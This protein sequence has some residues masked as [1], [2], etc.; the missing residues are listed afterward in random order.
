M[1]ITNAALG[2]TTALIIPDP[3]AAAGQFVLTDS[4][5]K[6]I[7]SCGGANRTITLSGNLTT[8]GAFNAT[9]AVPSSSTWTLPTGGGTLLTDPADI[10]AT[11]SETFTLN[12]GATKS[13]V[14]STNTTGGGV[15]IVTLENGDTTGSNRT[16]TLPDA[17]TTLVGTD[18][19]Q[20][21]STKTLTAP[22][23]NGATS[24]GASN[25]DLSGC[26]GTF[27]TTTGTVTI[28][29]GAVSVTG[30]VTFAS[31]VTIGHSGGAGSFDLSSASGTFDTSTGT[32]T[33]RG[34]VTISG[35][36]T[37]TTGTGAAVLKGSATFDTTKS[38][39]FGAA[40]GGTAIPITMYSLTAS[41]GAFILASADN[42]T[43][44]A[45][46]LT[47]GP[48]N[49]A[50]ATITT[51]ASTCTLSG[52]GLAETFSGIKTFSVAPVV[53]IDDATDNAVTDLLSIKHTTSGG[54]SAGM[55]AGISVLIEN[56]T[57]ATTEA[58]SVDFVMTND[59]TKATLDVDVV[60]NTML[61]GAVQP[62]LTVDA[63]DQSVTIGQNVTDT[64]GVNQVRIYPRTASMGS[65]LLTVVNNTGDTVTQ[66]TNAGF[67]QATV[68][69]IP[70]PGAATCNLAYGDSSGKIA[71]ANM[72]AAVQDL[73]PTMSITAGAEAAHAR[74]ITFQVKDA[75]SNNLSEY[76]I[77]RFFIN[78]TAS[79]TAP[80]ATGT[81]TFGAPSA[82]AIMVTNTAKADYTVV[83]DATGKYV[84]ELTHN[85]AGTSRFVT[86]QLGAK[87][88]VS[89]EITFDAV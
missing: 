47:N 79:Y 70:D 28:G 21:L 25:F 72:A 33:L 37:L 60:V 67:G 69:T 81:D 45:V 46:T 34:N 54:P 10:A 20:T 88:V 27:L 16:I 23:I 58:A 55:G 86:A 26:S 59:G 74:L 5:H 51:P 57:D 38:L 31:G 78:A 41:K 4:A 35:S 12:N 40:G 71:V 83:T 63:S 66:I 48:A 18:T 56:D 77:I 19:T 14:L 13:L 62:A 30:N 53:L 11:T 75:A 9:I 24:S 22:V 36:K 61:G 44:H 32:N 2:Q 15:G 80:S 39:T 64:D 76:C 50:A 17:T 6:L 68:I 7:V 82:G 43:D 8:T 87:A 52:L 42:T 49:G 84:F 29:N 73:M 89:G 65:L 85:D 3:G 1:T